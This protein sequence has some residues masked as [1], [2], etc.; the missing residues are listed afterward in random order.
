[1][2]KE[3][4]D[5]SIRDALPSD[6][7]GICDLWSQLFGLHAELD[8]IFTPA[9]DGRDHYRRWLR[10]Q[11]MDPDAIVM[12]AE[13]DTEVAAYIMAKI[14][15]LPPVMR[16]KRIGIISD[17]CVDERLRSHHLGRM[18]YK[19]LELRMLD[20]GVTRLELKTSSLNPQANHFWEEVCGFK[21]FVK[22]R[23][24]EFE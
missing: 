20:R 23:Y 24:K 12:V 1:M 18:L 9:E 6:V 5:I 19:D 17:A 11:M 16:F 8:P 2:R 21:E 7:E 13:V 15:T 3:I 14:S 4:M 10:S 22:V